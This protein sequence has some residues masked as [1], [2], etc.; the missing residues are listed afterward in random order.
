MEKVARITASGNVVLGSWL[1][2]VPFVFGTSAISRWNDVLVGLTVVLVAGHNYARVVE[3]RPMSGAGAGLVTTFGIW[4]IV[5]PFVF[6]LAGAELWHD[7]VWGTLVAS[8][9]SYN[10]YIATLTGRTQPLRMASE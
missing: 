9:G 5:E 4:L 10:A 2:A 8:F 1:L 6:G 3:R 7:V